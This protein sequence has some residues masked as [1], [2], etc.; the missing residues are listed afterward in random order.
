MTVSLATRARWYALFVAHSIAYLQAFKLPHRRHEAELHRLRT[1]YPIRAD[2]VIGGGVV[3]GVRLR[4]L[5]PRFWEMPVI[6]RFILRISPSRM[7][8]Y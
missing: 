1:R 8:L 4:R 6:T 5:R 3:P 7:V 2:R